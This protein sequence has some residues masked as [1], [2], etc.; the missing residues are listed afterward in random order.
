MAEQASVRANQQDY[1]TFTLQAL[2]DKCGRREISPQAGRKAKKEDY[3]ARL[4]QYDRDHAHGRL[5]VN[6]RRA[7][8][9]T[10]RP[11]TIQKKDGIFPRLIK[12]GQGLWALVWAWVRGSSFGTTFYLLVLF[13]A[14][15]AFAAVWDRKASKELKIKVLAYIEPRMP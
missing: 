6:R 4:I 12:W 7:L 1:P 15:S 3:V 14:F 2:K 13:I 11:Y 9:T 5:Q 10:S 8:L